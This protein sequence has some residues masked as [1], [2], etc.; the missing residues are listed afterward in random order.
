MSN[1]WF[2]EFVQNI[3][4][5]QSL[6]VIHFQFI[7]QKM[8]SLSVE[9]ILFHF[10]N[11]GTYHRGNIVHALHHANVVHQADTYLFLFI[12]LSL[13]VEGDDLNRL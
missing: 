10:I 13:S 5:E 3:S 11:Y 9:E 6:E 2:I 8:G 7:D 12:S 1:Q 4:S